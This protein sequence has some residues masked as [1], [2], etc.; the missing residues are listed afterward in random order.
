MLAFIP[1]VTLAAAFGFASASPIAARQ[2]SARFG[3]IT[4]QPST[5]KLGEASDFSRSACSMS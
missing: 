1:L 2:E 4:V 3:A 5:V